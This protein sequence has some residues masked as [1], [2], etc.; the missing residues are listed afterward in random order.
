M[1]N[2]LSNCTKLLQRWRLLKRI[3]GLLVGDIS[4]PAAVLLLPSQRRVWRLAGLLQSVAG[5]HTAHEGFGTSGA[6]GAATGPM[7]D[8]KFTQSTYVRNC[9]LQGLLSR[10]AGLF[11]GGA[12]GRAASGARASTSNST[13]DFL[14]QSDDPDRRRLQAAATQGTGATLNTPS[15]PLHIFPAL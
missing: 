2:N 12:G 4:A 11:S 7:C 10:L 6:V 13:P 1:A 5:A 9:F 14:A 8:Y 3:A 15:Q